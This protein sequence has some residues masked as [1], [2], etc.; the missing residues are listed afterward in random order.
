MSRK[1]RGCEVDNFCD[2]QSK[3]MSYKACI[4]PHP[5]VSNWI[6]AFT[7]TNNI[8]KILCSWGCHVKVSNTFRKRHTTWRKILGSVETT[9]LKFTPCVQCLIV[10]W[11]CIFEKNTLAFYWRLANYFLQPEITLKELILINTKRLTA[12]WPVRWVVRHQLLS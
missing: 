6:L 3:I 11:N 7:R 8:N 2:K 4:H 1:F 5:D 9:Y 10:I 12:K